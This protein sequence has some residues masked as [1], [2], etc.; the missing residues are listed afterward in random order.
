MKIKIPRGWAVLDNKFY[1]TNPL[2]DEGS[3]FINNWYEGF[4]EDVLWIKECSVTQDGKFEIPDKNHFY[5]DITWFPDSRINGQYYATLFWMALDE[6][7]E[8]EYFESKDRF[9]V[10]KKIEFWIEDIKSFNSEY[11]KRITK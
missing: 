4:I 11:Q 10:C 6:V 9:Q 5:I 3:D 2:V 8:I 7:T 1:D